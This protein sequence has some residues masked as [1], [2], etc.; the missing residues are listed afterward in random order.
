MYVHVPMEQSTRRAAGSP[1]QVL[2]ERPHPDL[3]RTS[4]PGERRAIIFDIDGTLVNS[5][6][7]HAFA[8]VDAL[9]AYGVMIPFPRVRS[10]MGME[11]EKLLPELAGITL[12]SGI[13]RR[14]HHARAEFFESRYLQ[15]VRP[16]PRARDL[17]QRTIDAGFVPAVISNSSHD[18]VDRL[19]MRAEVADL[20]K[21]RIL[22]ESSPA[23][24]P[25]S[26]LMFFALRALGV[27]ASSAVAVGATPHDIAAA[28]RAGVSA[29]AL[30]CGGW[31]D[32]ELA[33][34]AAVY[35]DPAELLSRF[36]DSLLSDLPFKH[37]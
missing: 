18:H 32:H 34:A 24:R 37:N 2:H 14:I 7:A 29:I 8:W 21:L 9:K 31:D 35:Q 4:F 30:R 20:L 6:D 10:L 27:P 25:L 15:R 33:G 36:D 19:L 22:S 12:T 13:G 26:E 16:F 3:R 11:P 17:V 1:L 23:G 28:Q 5:N